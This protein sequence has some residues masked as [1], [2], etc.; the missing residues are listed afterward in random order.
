MMAQTDELIDSDRGQ[1]RVLRRVESDR[2][3]ARY[4][5]RCACGV[6]RSVQGCHLRSGQSQS[7]GCG[8]RKGRRHKQWKGHGEISADYWNDI[9]RG[10]NGNKGK[11]SPV[12]FE[13][14]IE[15]A[16]ELFIEQGRTCA[17]T[18]L[19]LVVNYGRKTGPPHTASLDRMDAAKGYVPGN[20]QWLHKDV[21][22]M[23]RTFAE[24]Y[25]IELCVRVA[26]HQSAG[27]LCVTNL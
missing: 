10:A 23:K 22:M 18:G 20:V 15:Y 6:V 4:E 21:N 19:P 16:W 1:W 2:R 12:P 3:H 13:I 14:T 17:L 8:L 5:C 24:E 7:C 25:F 27:G 11:R 26:S 9:R